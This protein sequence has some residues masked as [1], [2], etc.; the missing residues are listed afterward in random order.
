M[1][2]KLATRWWNL[3]FNLGYAIGGFQHARRDY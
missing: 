3:R 1:I 2:Q